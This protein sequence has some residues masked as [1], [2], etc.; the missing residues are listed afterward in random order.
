M[1]AESWQRIALTSR[2]E[3]R[4]D[5]IERVLAAAVGKGL[6]G[7]AEEV[8][9]IPQASGF[10]G[11]LSSLTF[12]EVVRTVRDRSLRGRLEVAIGDD[13]FVLH[14]DGLYLEE[15][16]ALSGNVDGLL[17]EIL[18]QGG[19]IDDRTYAELLDAYDSGQFIG[20]LELELARKNVVADATLQSARVVRAREVF[21]RLCASRGGQFAFLEIRV[22]DGQPWP[23]DRLR[24]NVDQ[25]MLELLRESSIDTGDSQATASTML[26]LDPNRAAAIEPGRLTDEER[27]VMMFFRDGDTLEA[28]RDRLQKQAGPEDVDRIVNRLKKVELLKRSNPRIVVPA[29]LDEKAPA[30]PASE[31][32]TADRKS[33]KRTGETVVSPVSDVMSEDERRRL[34]D[35]AE[36]PTDKTTSLKANWD[37]IPDTSELD[38]LIDEGIAAYETEATEVHD[39]SE[40]D[41]PS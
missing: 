12:V 9:R 29:N 30:V 32:D 40:S 33:P 23:V 38:E 28:A 14:M 22:G 18:H 39:G 34:N 5:Q 27:S 41:E 2:T 31:A 17:L 1:L 8:Q 24:I 3:D 13:A 26:Q 6:R 21:R 20:P 15:I 36:Q 19:A 4:A 35:T 7:A 10:S 11:A 37:L 25:L 16:D